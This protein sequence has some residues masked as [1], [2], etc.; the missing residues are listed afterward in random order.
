MDS[1]IDV[2]AKRYRYTGME[3]DEETGLAYHSARYYASWLG[4]W[5]EADPIGLGG[6]GNRYEFAS[7]NPILLMDLSGLSPLQD[8]QEAVVD[9]QI[10]LRRAQDPDSYRRAERRLQYAQAQI[11]HV[12]E[13][14]A[15]AK[16]VLYTVSEAAG[17]TV[18]GAVT[19]L[20]KT[21]AQQPSHTPNA[22]S[23][24]TTVSYYIENPGDAAFD[25][26][27]AYGSLL[28]AGIERPTKAV[29]EG[30]S[31]NATA[32]G[33]GLVSTLSD[34]VG[35]AAAN[36]KGVLANVEGTVSGVVGIGDAVAG[37]DFSAASDEYIKA[38]KNAWALA[39]KWVDLKSFLT[40]RRALSS[41][42]A[43]AELPPASSAPSA[44][45]S[46]SQPKVLFGQANVGKKFANGPFAGRTIGEVADGLRNGTIS[47][48]QLPLDVIIHSGQTIT[49]NNRSLTALRRAG[50]EPTII[51]DRTGIPEFEQQLI[52]QLRGSKPSDV[53]RIRAGQP[54]RS[55]LE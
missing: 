12:G 54:D 34:P 46:P 55:S 7:G 20:G 2:S 30:L 5:T 50:V 8:L 36:G 17:T 21:F 25:A 23:A 53:I 37:G 38:G 48:D 1:S 22:G 31:R 32:I 41:P 10:E 26:M 35:A 44:L 24:V 52:D 9:A 27:G 39:A 6:G 18:G 42:K 13:A 11:Q 28:E 19:T 49:L 16:Q 15:Q 3:R 40:A 51:R 33:E 45:S 43:S 29:V 47:P 14:Y 4:R